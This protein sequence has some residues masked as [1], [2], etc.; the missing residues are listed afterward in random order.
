[1]YL[2][3]SFGYA[4][5]AYSKAAAKV[6]FQQIFIW[7][8]GNVNLADAILRSTLGFYFG[9]YLRLPASTP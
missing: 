5:N 8:W 6:S 7:E 3:R 9:A 2:E 1:M 4:R